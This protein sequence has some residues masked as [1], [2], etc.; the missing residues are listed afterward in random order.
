MSKRQAAGRRLSSGFNRGQAAVEMAVEG[1]ERRSLMAATLLPLG[2]MLPAAKAASAKPVVTVLAK[3]STATT[4]AKTTA[5]TKATTRAKGSSVVATPAVVGPAPVITEFVASNATGLTDGAGNHPDWIE[6]QNQGDTAVDLAGW[7]LSDT[8]SNRAKWTFPSVTVAP[9]AY[10][11]VFAD[12]AAASGPDAQGYLHTNFS[13]S[14]DG[15]N[16]SLSKPDNTVVSEYGSAGAL[17]PKQAPDVSY[18]T[19]TI[20]TPTNLITAGA[21]ARAIAPTNGTVDSSN[22][23]TLPGYA[24]GTWKSGTTGVGY[25]GGGTASVSGLLARWY[26]P[27]LGTGTGALTDNAAVQNWAAATGTGTATQNTSSKRPTYQ[28]DA[29]SLINGKAV[30]RF[31]GNNDNLL[32]TNQSLNSLGNFTVAMV[33]KTSTAGRAGTNWYDNTGIVDAEV[34]G[35]TDDWGL[36]LNATGQIGAGVGN[37]DITTYAGNALANG[38]AHSVVMSKSGTQVAVSIDGGAPIYN[39]VG[40]GARTINEVMF[41]SIHTNI[42]FFNGDLGEV[43]FYSNALSDDSARSLSTELDSTWGITPAAGIYTPK[44]GLDLQTEMANVASTANIRVPF[45]VDTPSQYDKLFL[46]M[47]YDDGFV[48]YLNGTEVARRNAPGGAITYTSV[49]TATRSDAN[50]LTAETIDISSFRNLLTGGGATNILA[51]KALNVSAADSDLLVIPEVVAATSYTGAAYM[52]QPSPGA[53]NTVGYAGLVASPTANVQHGYYSAPQSVT[54]TTAT[55]GATLV[56]TTDGSA[57]T[58]DNGT[59]VLSGSATVS[60]AATLTVSSTTVLRMAAFRAGYVQSGIT[61]ESYMFLSD[62]LTQPEYKPAGAYWDVGM[63]TDVV[64]N[65]TYQ[66]NGTAQQPQQWTVA[67][68]LTAIPTISLSISNGDMFG[69]DN[70]IYT[71]PL[72]EGDAWERPVSVEYFDPNNA[73]NQFSINAGIRI[74]GSVSR[75]TSRPKKGFKLFFRSEYGTSKL[76]YPVFGSTNPQTV[77]D[78]L[79]LRAGHNHSWANLGGTSVTSGDYLRDQFARDTQ[80]ALTGK[81]AAGDW[82]QV[83][84]NGQ[85]WGLYNTTEDVDTDWAQANYGG[86]GDDYDIIKPNDNGGIDADDGTLD[87]WNTLFSTADAAY[88]DGVVS[89]AEYQNLSAQVDVKNLADYMISCFYRGDQDSPVL[90]GSADSPRNFIALHNRAGVN[91]GKFLFQTQDGELSIDDIAFDRT[92]VYGNQNPG[93]LF[94]QLRTNPDFRSLVADEISKAFGTNGALTTAA[95]QARYRADMARIDKAIVGESARWGNA[96]QTYVATRD[97][98][99]VG[100]TGWILNTYFPQR[101]TVAMNQFKADFPELNVISPTVSVNGTPSTGGVITSGA[102]VTL[103]DANSPAGQVY[104]TLDGTD[105]RGTSGAVGSTAVLYSGA[106]TLPGART[107]N[108]RTLKGGVWSPIAT[109]AFTVAPP[110]LRL[111]EM[112]YHPTVPTGGSYAKDEYEFIEVANTGLTPI[113]LSGMVLN[114]GAAATVANGTTLAAGARGVFVKNAAAFR[115]RYGPSA[116]ILGEYTDYLS[117]SGERVTLYDANSGTN[118][119]D[120]TYVD[121]WYPTTDGNGYSLVVKDLAPSQAVATVLG[122]A[123][124]WRASV[125]VGGTPG[126]DDVVL[127]AVKLTGMTVDDGTAQHSLVRRATLLFDGT[128]TS[129]NFAAGAITLTQT[130]GT[131][132]PWTAIISG[133]TMPVAGQTAVSVTFTGSAA[134]FGSLADGRYTLHIDGGKIVDALGR[135]VDAVGAGTVGSAKDFAV[136]RLYGDLDGDFGVSINDFNA[137]AT[138]FGALTGNAAYNAAFDYD[139]DNG[140]SINDFN[141]F[142]SRFGKTI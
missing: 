97:V 56:Y 29:A 79:I 87:A 7:H 34:G 110:S 88:A 17:Y 129:A 111:S 68:A 10:L 132:S 1:L 112:M 108:A 41:G 95:N 121:S 28:S 98:D 137:F 136:A 69:A 102:S 15:E 141:Q 4:P 14:A 78:H 50:A 119:F 73:A 47:K 99:W 20:I 8:A 42:Q 130:T 27:S 113:D 65:T 37:P 131:I 123:T 59:K 24:D 94:H 100:E 124:A 122:V 22:A 70:G 81:S 90:I 139:A 13:L 82:A 33:F 6:I 116:Q 57:P 43:R 58:L 12:S 104:Y 55:P 96:L 44:I 128:L 64:N 39:T 60:P 23:W 76:D 54:L 38:Q 92:E 19:S 51:I 101:A 86:N 77:F 36:A 26:A 109:V 35:V 85:Y 32:V 45:T 84:I 53:A 3:S 71:H 16:L 107:L 89:A 118:I 126:L 125:S 72:Q 11:V 67:Q 40:A 18:G 46:N 105:P 5:G 75:E 103:S 61:A 2:K 83:Y 133:V 74:S 62:I 138:A 142:A 115:Q 93:R 52:P 140:I 25:D 91:G 135:P 30:V 31:D 66:V 63:D 127:P 49:S 21:P 120:V 48:A 117:N 80:K 114:T 134:E 106:F 9:G